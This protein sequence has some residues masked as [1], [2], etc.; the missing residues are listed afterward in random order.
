MERQGTSTIIQ[1]VRDGDIVTPYAVHRAWHHGEFR[2]TARWRVPF[3]QL[4]R[5]PVPF[6]TPPGSL[7][8]G[9]QDLVA[10]GFTKPALH[11]FDSH[12]YLAL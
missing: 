1:Y 9:R 11:T 3:T 7:A 5:E 2:E 12:P 6:G 4:K 8:Y 10:G